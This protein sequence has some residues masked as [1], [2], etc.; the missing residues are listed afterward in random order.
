MTSMNFYKTEMHIVPDERKSG[1]RKD[2]ITLKSVKTFIVSDTIV[3]RIA[4]YLNL[5]MNPSSCHSCRTFCHYLTLQSSDN[6]N[7]K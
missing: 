5:I 7:F 1:S 6:Y 2:L 3:G 4:D